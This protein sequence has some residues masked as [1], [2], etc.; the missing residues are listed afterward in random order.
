M[1]VNVEKNEYHQ[2]VKD[3]KTKKV[4]HEEHEPL[5]EHKK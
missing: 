4:L 5:T 1:D 3:D 2:V